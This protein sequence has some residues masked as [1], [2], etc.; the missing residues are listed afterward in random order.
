[1]IRQSLEKKGLTNLKDAAKVLGISTELLRVTIN[2]GHV[3]KDSTISMIAKKLGLDPS[4]LILTAHQ[5]KVPAEM[6]G[7]FLVLSQPKEG[8]GKRVFPLSQEQCTYLEKIMNPQEIQLIRK[9]RQVSEDA[10]TQIIGYINYMF[11]TRKIEVKT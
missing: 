10:K 6:K 7:F 9:V 8:Q 4:A 5:E 3:P 1:M 11:A 2:K